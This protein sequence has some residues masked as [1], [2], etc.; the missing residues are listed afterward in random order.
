MISEEHTPVEH[1]PDVPVP[2]VAWKAFAKQGKV[3][4]S[5]IFNL[6]PFVYEVNKPVEARCCGVTRTIV[7][8]LGG[9]QLMPPELQPMLDAHGKT[10]GTN[11]SCGFY[12]TKEKR[13]ALPAGAYVGRVRVWGKVIEHEQGYRAQYL[14]LMEIPKRS[15]H[16]FAMFKLPWWWWTFWFLWV[17]ARPISHLMQMPRLEAILTWGTLVFLIPMIWDVIYRLNPKHSNSISS[18]RAII[19]NIKW[20]WNYRKNRKR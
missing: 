9:R 6:D 17:I 15:Y 13:L 3:Y 1:I 11:C 7:Q 4:V 8:F 19:N 5:P 14:E 18:G 12:V 20:L 10:P 2:I 16:I